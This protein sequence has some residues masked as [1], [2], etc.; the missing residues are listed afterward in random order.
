MVN[1]QFLISMAL[2]CL[3]N[4]RIET[5][6]N[7]PT[8]NKRVASLNEKFWSLETI[9]SDSIEDPLYFSISEDK[10]IDSLYS[11]KRLDLGCL[12]FFAF[13]RELT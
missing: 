11:F 7:N 1:L 13:P 5:L 6:E 3:S 10:P 9:V 12:V 4:Y 8:K 2:D